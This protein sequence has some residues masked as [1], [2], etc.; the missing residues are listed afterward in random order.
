MWCHEVARIRLLHAA[1]RLPALWQ[2]QGQ[3]DR[4]V[5]KLISINKHRGRIQ[6]GMV[7]I[8]V[9]C[10]VSE[11]VRINTVSN[12]DI[13][14]AGIGPADSPGRLGGLLEGKRLTILIADLQARDSANEVQHQ[15]QTGTPH[16]QVKIQRVSGHLSESRLN[17][18]L[19]HIAFGQVHLIAGFSGA[20]CPA[21][22]DQY[23]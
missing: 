20:D 2:V 10:A 3:V 8:D 17:G 5:A 21:Q 9:A 18:H 14:A 7:R 11:A 6:K 15:I 23:D 1:G 13:P 12:H 22:T 16:G 4:Q 19:L